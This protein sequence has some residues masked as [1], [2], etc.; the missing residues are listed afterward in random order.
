M[1]LRTLI[2]TAEPHVPGRVRLERGVKPPPPAAEPAAAHP[3]TPQGGQ[4]AGSNVHPGAPMA[5]RA[6]NG[7]QVLHD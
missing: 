4:G 5:V 1:P 7:F 3:L 2:R 6:G